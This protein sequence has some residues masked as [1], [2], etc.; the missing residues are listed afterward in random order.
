[1]PE[2]ISEPVQTPFVRLD[3][4]D[5]SLL[6]SHPSEIIETSEP[7]SVKYCLSQLRG[8]DA[9]GFLTYEAGHSLESKLESIARVAKSGELP[10]LWFGLFERVEEAPPLPDPQGAWAG[11]PVPAITFDHYQTSVEA[12]RR[13]IADGDIY[14]L[15]FTFPCAVPVAGNPSALYAQL[16]ARSGAGW[17]A[18]VFTG[19]HWLLSLSPELFFTLRD[20][21]VTCRPMKGTAPPGSDPQLLSSDPK[22]RAENLMIVDLVRNDLSRVCKPGSVKVPELYRVEHYPTVLQ[23]TSTVTA[24]LVDGAGLT[25]LIESTF[26]CGSITGA[27]KIRAMERIEELEKG[28]CGLRGAY[29]GSIGHVSA[30]GDA[31]FNVAIRTLILGAG[32]SVAQYHVGSAIVTDSDPR[33]EWQECLQKAAFVAS[34]NHF[35]LLE[36]FAFGPAHFPLVPL[37]LDRLQ[38]SAR[39]LGFTFDRARLEAELEKIRARLEDTT[40]L[41]IVLDRSGMFRV[42]ERPMPSVLPGKIEVA[43][44]DRSNDS[45]DFRLAYKTSDRAFYDDARAQAGTFE[46]LF[47]DQEKFLTEGSF[48]NLFVRRADR[49]L[50]PPV[51]RGL[52]PGIL[53]QSLLEQGVAEEADLCPSDLGHDFWIGNSLRGLLPA[54][55]NT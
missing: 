47:V 55:L 53:R 14:Q 40:R 10:L 11:K 25:D 23:M 49:L 27:P 13:Y 30:D 6:Y 21:H 39:D 24:D 42:E 8:R 33:S 31:A 48:T 29:T 37:H 26:P 50:T 35:D 51:S 12:I 20:G 36:T 4:G 1:M 38:R 32:N 19:T 15:N 54:V 2:G 28:M 7:S 17:S 9:A 46:I 41:R 52:L 44:R 45:D 3:F 34:P 16:R 18:Q 22:N 5:R 43:L